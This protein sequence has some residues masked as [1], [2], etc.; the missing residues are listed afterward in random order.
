[1][2]VCGAF[3]LRVN[4]R[5]DDGAVGGDTRMNGEGDWKASLVVTIRATN[6]VTMRRVVMVDLPTRLVRSD[7]GRV[8]LIREGPLPS[9]VRFSLSNTSFLHNQGKG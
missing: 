8:G 2:V 9:V 3:G 4:G 5:D 6:P 7:L 1:M